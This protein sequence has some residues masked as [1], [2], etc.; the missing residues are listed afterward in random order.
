MKR[1]VDLSALV[2]GLWGQVGCVLILAFHVLRVWRFGVSVHVL[3]GSATLGIQARGPT[4]TKGSGGREALED[5]LESSCLGQA[6][7]SGSLH[8]S[9]KK[10]RGRPMAY[11]VPMSFWRTPSTLRI[12]TKRNESLYPSFIN[13]ALQLLSSK[14]VVARIYSLSPSFETFFPNCIVY[15]LY[16]WGAIPDTPNLCKTSPKHTELA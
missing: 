7:C 4:R 8:G 16:K 2:L 11:Q 14:L 5:H 13:V 6:R 1:V 3:G 15:T 10:S 12:Q 9:F